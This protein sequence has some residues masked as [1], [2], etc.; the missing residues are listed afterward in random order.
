M[1]AGKYSYSLLNM[2]GQVLMQHSLQL[3]SNAVQQIQLPASLPAGTYQMVLQN[4]TE[5]WAQTVVKQ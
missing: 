3:S 4:A 2:N 5:R 1:T